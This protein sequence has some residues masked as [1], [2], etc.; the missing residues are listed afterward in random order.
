MH[1][2]CASLRL[3]IS[4]AK[5][6]MMMCTIKKIQCPEAL[7]VNCST[8]FKIG[9]DEQKTL[10]TLVKTHYA[11]FHG[12]IL[13]TTLLLGQQTGRFQPHAFEGAEANSYAS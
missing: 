2:K 8:W 7:G 12:E 5:K 6:M 13:T 4:D 10:L 1:N 3:F 11:K 9:R